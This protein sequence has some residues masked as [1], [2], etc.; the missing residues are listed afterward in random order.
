MFV[1][2]GGFDPEDEH[3]NSYMWFLYSMRKATRKMM[4][5]MNSASELTGLPSYALFKR[6]PPEGSESGMGE[7]EGQVSEVEGP[8][9][10]EVQN[11]ASGEVMEGEVMEG[12]VMEGEVMEGEVM[13]GEVME[14]EVSQDS[15]GEVSDDSEGS[16]NSETSSVSALASRL[17]PANVKSSSLEKLLS[18][19]HKHLRRIFSEMK[20]I[21]HLC[22]SEGVFDARWQMMRAYT[23]LL[24][25]HPF[26]VSYEKVR[27]SVDL[28]FEAVLRMDL[29][30]VSGYHIKNSAGLQTIPLD[31]Q[32]Q[33]DIKL[34]RQSFREI[35][36]AMEK[37]DEKKEQEEYK[38]PPGRYFIEIPPGLLKL[39]GD[40][41]EAVTWEQNYLLGQ[42]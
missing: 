39:L 37:E 28:S 18:C 12:E 25:T 34:F 42:V 24:R 40:R 11:D 27:D 10:S 17:A 1:E 16:T 2:R 4:I 23:F 14:G 19:M 5:I 32:H 41:D 3:E 13:E 29:Q 26:G 21:F 30:L 7:G 6:L 22:L 36:L 31:A 33:E 20:A 38:L 9:T 8:E 35:E 15:E